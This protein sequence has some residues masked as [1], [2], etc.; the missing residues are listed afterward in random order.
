MR[1][2]PGM[3]DSHMPATRLKSPRI[4]FC[5]VTPDLWADLEQLFGSRG[6]CGGCWCMWP[7]STRADFE[8]NKGSANKRALRRIVASGNPPGLLA[9]ADNVPVGWCALAPRETYIRLERSRIL[10]PVDDQPVWS[11]ICFFVTRAF[12]RQGLSVQ[13]LRAA[14]AHAKKHGARIVEGYPTDSESGRDPDAFVWTGLAATFRA[15]G[16]V[17]VARRSARRPI[18]R[19]CIPKSGC[20]RK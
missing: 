14:I 13:L 11:V 19:Y 1:P 12:R 2:L 3:S 7:R 5:A 6:A 16:F 18:M 8:R 4:T 15:A 20:R 9:Y 10:Q 17:E